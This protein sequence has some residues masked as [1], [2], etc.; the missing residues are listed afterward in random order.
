MRKHVAL[1]AVVLLACSGEDG[2]AGPAGKDGLNATGA[3]GADGKPGASGAAGAPG[4]NG[5]AGAPGQ[6]GDA[7]AAGDAGPQGPMGV[8]GGGPQWVDGNGDPVTVV[9]VRP[10]VVVL[11]NGVLWTYSTLTGTL[12]V[13]GG[14]N[15]T[16]AYATNDCTG[17]VYVLLASDIPGWP[18]RVLDATAA[19]PTLDTY[20][21][22]VDLVQKLSLPS[23]YQEGP[24][25]VWTCKPRSAGAVHARPLASL[26]K[27]TPPAFTPPLHLAP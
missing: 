17:P 8:P 14:S 15:L 10:N 9:D 7:G 6:L 20:A 12:G 3:P 5:E 26:V 22:G 24:A 4:A 13:E 11:V 19:G 18:F 21:A 2:P 16:T 27:V 23:S 1:L 25:G